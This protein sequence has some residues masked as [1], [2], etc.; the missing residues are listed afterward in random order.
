MQRLFDEQNMNQYETYEKSSW[1]IKNK[2]YKLLDNS[3][4]KNQFIINSNIDVII[5]TTSNV[6]NF[7]EFTLI[8]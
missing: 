1:K 5:D 2:L 7:D 3:E 6:M 8:N 4:I